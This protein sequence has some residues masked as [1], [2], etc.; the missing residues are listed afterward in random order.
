MLGAEQDQKLTFD[1]YVKK[2][3]M[4]KEI[5]RLKGNNAESHEIASMST[6]TEFTLGNL[7]NHNENMNSQKKKQQEFEEKVERILYNISVDPKSRVE[8]KKEEPEVLLEVALRLYSEIRK[9]NEGMIND[10]N[11]YLRSSMK[12]NSVPY[13][14]TVGLQLESCLQ[15]FQNAYDA[16]EPPHEI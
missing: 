11:N 16:E 14:T 6:E 8:M 9:E 5:E 3:K 2:R 1:E 10:L 4:D 15:F 12:R 13:G 7:E